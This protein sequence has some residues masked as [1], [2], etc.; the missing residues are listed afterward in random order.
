MAIEQD[1]NISINGFNSEDDANTIGYFV[2][3]AIRTL[4]EKFG[5][6]LSKLRSVVI[7]YDFASALQ[8]VTSGY[9][10]KSPSS[11]TK[12]SQGEAVGQLVAKMDPSGHHAEFTL[13][14]SAV[15]FVELFSDEGKIVATPDGVKAVIHKIHHELAHVHEF[16]T[17]TT[18]DNNFTVGEYGNAV[19]LTA[20][21]AWSEYLAN[22]LSAPTAP[23]ESVDIF[24]EHYNNVIKEVPSE[25]Y[26]FKEKYCTR[27]IPL[28]QMFHEVNKR[29]KLIVD[30]CGY[31]MGYVHSLNID[32]EDYFPELPKSLN[33]KHL[34]ISF[35][36]LSEAFS[37]LRIKYENNELKTLDDYKS[38][39]ETIDNIYKE[40]GITLDSD[41]WGSESGLYIHVN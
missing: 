8:K 23:Q 16:N 37:D 36:T 11:F 28:N 7:S 29:I 33:D 18:L 25:I 5:L 21:K 39:A 35:A 17:I 14:L 34:S 31:A 12:S 13:V 24:L 1:L 2:L 3:D 19:L 30:A 6:S 27:V 40:F 9:S 38:I 32:I 4:D 20:K 26:E 10:H 15:F 41:G 22:Y